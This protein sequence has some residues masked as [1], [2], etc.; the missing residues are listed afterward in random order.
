MIVFVKQLLMGVVSR[1]FCGG[2]FVINRFFIFKVRGLVFL[3]VIIG[4]M[5]LGGVRVG[6]FGFLVFFLFGLEQDQG[7]EQLM[8]ER[9]FVFW[10][11]R[12]GMLVFEDINFYCRVF[13]KVLNFRIFFSCIV[14]F[15]GSEFC[16]GR[17]EKSGLFRQ[18]FE[19]VVCLVFRVEEGVIVDSRFSRVELGE[20][21][22]VGQLN[23]YRIAGL[24]LVGFRGGWRV[25]R[26]VQEI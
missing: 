7:C 12:E 13:I 21:G 25:D 18:G 22:K 2:F 15:F 23:R 14:S 19:E 16:I 6:M 9:F 1:W 5:L 17:R 4:L 11:Y 20:Q 24:C 26:I 3:N 8:S 10:D